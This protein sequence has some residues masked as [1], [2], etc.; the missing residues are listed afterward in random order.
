V[1]LD[2]LDLVDQLDNLDK[3]VLQ[4]QLVNKGLVERLDQLDSEANQGHQVKLVQKE[5]R[6]SKDLLGLLEA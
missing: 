3:E 2:Q 4:G 5:L 1:N 6:D